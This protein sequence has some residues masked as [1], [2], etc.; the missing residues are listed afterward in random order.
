VAW[1]VEGRVGWPVD[2]IVITLVA[3]INA[4]LGYVQ[5]AKAENALPLWRASRR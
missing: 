1:A 2:A 4:V 5:E 3:L